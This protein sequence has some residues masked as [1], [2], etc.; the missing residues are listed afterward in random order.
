MPV[1]DVALCV[2]PVEVVVG[3]DKFDCRLEFVNVRCLLEE[4]PALL[5]SNL[6]LEEGGV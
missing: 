6:I 1:T 5:A 4:L 3:P 2:C